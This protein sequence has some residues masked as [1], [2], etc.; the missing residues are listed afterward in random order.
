[1]SNAKARKLQCLLI[2]ELLEN[3]SVE[4]ILPDGITLEVGILQKD[5]FG[6]VSKADGYCYV[7]ATRAGKTTLLDSYNLGVQY[8]P[9]SDTIIFEDEITDDNGKVVKTLDV[10]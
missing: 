6:N 5:K 10:I 7:V 2:K 1:M 3:G 4:L 9:E 8:E